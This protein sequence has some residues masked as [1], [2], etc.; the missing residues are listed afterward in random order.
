MLLTNKAA[1]VTGAAGN[2]GFAV[3]RRLLKEGARVLLVDVNEPELRAAFDRLAGEQSDWKERAATFSRARHRA[4]RQ[5]R[6]V[7]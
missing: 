3:T 7:L 6:R 2:I 5:D 4:V 1:V